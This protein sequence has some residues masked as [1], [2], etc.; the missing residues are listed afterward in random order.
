MAQKAQS[1]GSVGPVP[2]QPG[3]ANA[4]P[5]AELADLLGRAGALLA[6]GRPDK[7]LDHVARAKVNSPW[8]ENALGVCQL[9]LGN[10][11]VALDVFRG[12]A[13]GP[14]GLILR[15]DVPAVFKTNFATALLASGNLPGAVSA[16]GRV[17]DEEHPAAPRLRAAVR[18]WE[19][20]LTFWQRLNWWLG[21]EPD[22]PLILDFPL[23]DL[24]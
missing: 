20:E 1:S 12:L 22:R 23:G 8:T 9:R 5:P 2:G 19:G 21:G 15:D 6:E 24:E 16:L 17:R 10:T 7:A 14:G 3:G 4:G 11:R 18:L 13:M